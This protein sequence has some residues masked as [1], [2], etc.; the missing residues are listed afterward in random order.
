[1]RRGEHLPP[2]VAG[3]S[4]LVVK[5]PLAGKARVGV[6]VLQHGEQLG[7]RGAGPRRGENCSVDG[8][9]GR[10]AGLQRLRRRAER[11]HARQ[12]DVQSIPLGGRGEERE[13]PE[14]PVRREGMA[15]E[16]GATSAAGQQDRRGEAAR[17]E[18]S[19]QVGGCVELP[20][21]GPKLAYRLDEGRRCVAAGR[22]VPLE[23]LRDERSP[24]GREIGGR[25]QRGSGLEPGTRDR[26]VPELLP[27]FLCGDAGP[28][29]VLV[30]DLR[31]VLRHAHGVRGG[32]GRDRPATAAE[33]PADV[34]RVAR[35]ERPGL[36]Q[37]QATFRFRFAH[38]KPRALSI[39]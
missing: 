2:G 1:M 8:G 32:S 22:A 14:R 26:L 38:A 10:D 33:E 15:V 36:R 34:G 20:P 6:R 4:S 5:P 13:R 16:R 17:V 23:L 21:V 37:R 12:R 11:D 30:Q 24:E 3:D 28:L 9:G 7:D 19:R 25:Q 18:P 27:P 39:S 29:D 35:L 31:R